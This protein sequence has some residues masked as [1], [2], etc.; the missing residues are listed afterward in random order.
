MIEIKVNG[1]VKTDSINK[2]AKRN[3]FA[4]NFDKI[5]QYLS[6]INWEVLFSYANDID[7]LYS[8]FL[9]VIHLSINTFVPMSNSHNNKKPT[10]KN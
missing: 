3:F 1:N 2:K 7:H 9:E 10:K 6:S 5:N 8:I 4:A